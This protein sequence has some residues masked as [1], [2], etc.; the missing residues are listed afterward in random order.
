MSEVWPREGQADRAARQSLPSGIT[1]PPAGV[2]RGELLRRAAAAGIAVPSIGAL[3]AACGGSSSTP[4]ASTP[5]TQVGSLMTTPPAKGALPQATWAL[6]YE[7]TSLDWTKAY[8]YA[9]NTVTANV[10]ESLYRLTPQLTYEPALATSYTQATPTKLVY[11]IRQ[12]VKFSDGSPMTVA[13]VVFSLRRNLTPSSFW[14]IWFANVK[15]VDQ[16]GTWEV[17]ITL[18]QPDSLVPSL[19][20]TPAGGV[21]SEKFI[22]AKGARYGTAG[23]GVLGTGPFSLQAWSVGQ[24]I[25]LVKNSQYWESAKV[26]K[27]STV[28]FVFIPDEGTLIGALLSGSVNGTY[29][30]PYSGVPE[31]KTSSAGT[32]YLGKDMTGVFLSPISPTGPLADVRVRQ[33]LLL[34]LDRQAIASV[35]YNGAAVPLK[36][37]TVPLEMW[38]YSNAAATAAYKALPAPTVDLARARSLIKQAGSPQKEIVIAVESTPQTWVQVGTIVE[39]AAKEIGLNARIRLVPPTQFGSFFF[40]PSARRGFD[41]WIVGYYADIPDPVEFLTELTIPSGKSFAASE[42]YWSY[43]NPTVTHAVSAARS[44]YDEATKTSMILAAQRAIANDLPQIPLVVPA[45]AL[46][47][48]EGITGVPASFC[49]LYYPWARDLGSS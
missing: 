36:N 5:V 44:S 9:E 22:R 33:A 8:N 40:D 32:L 17:T 29:G 28:K 30:A 12:G 20:A 25:T 35:A 39:A 31:L 26:A 45:V 18:S 46:F 19:M 4:A 47:L 16:T 2:T 24:G 48:G 27:T 37:T 23:G 42:D 10:T 21:G 43:N 13:D 49:Y 6:L 14:A 1:S 3:L 7:P 34:A 11:Q 15:S 38:G 41:A